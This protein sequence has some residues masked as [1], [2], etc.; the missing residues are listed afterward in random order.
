MR[1]DTAEDV[2]A[3]VEEVAKSRHDL[4]GDVDDGLR[5]MEIEPAALKRAVLNDALASLEQF[6]APRDGRDVLALLCTHSQM[7]FEVGATWGARRG[8][9]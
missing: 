4:G 6:G 1:L 2:R 8:S 5:A 9:A 7:W 3:L